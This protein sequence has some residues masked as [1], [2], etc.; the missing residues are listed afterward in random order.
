MQRIQSAKSAKQTGNLIQ[1]STVAAL[2]VLAVVFSTV[3]A[4]PIAIN[5]QNTPAIKLEAGTDS[6]N[7][8]SYPCAHVNIQ[9][10]N[11][12]IITFSLFPSEENTPQP[13]TYY[14]D[15]LKIENYGTA[16]A[17]INSVMVSGITGASNLGEITIYLFAEQTNNPETETAIGSATLTNQSNLTI[18]LL[19]QPYTLT[20]SATIH[21]EI[22]GYAAADATVDST[23]GFTLSAQTENA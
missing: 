4:S 13:A 1:Y 22:V 11:R 8:T 20:P 12:A 7:S 16:N 23:I 2:I 9:N 14:T 3:S 18:N 19:T 17:T 15:L 10:E 5:Q 6:S 21:V